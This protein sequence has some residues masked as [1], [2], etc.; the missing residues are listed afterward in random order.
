MPVADESAGDLADRFC[1][2]P[3]PPDGNSKNVDACRRYEPTDFQ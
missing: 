3:S 2:E 1:G